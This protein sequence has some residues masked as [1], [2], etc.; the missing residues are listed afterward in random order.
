MPLF[1]RELENRPLDPSEEFSKQYNHFFLAQELA[2]FDLRS[3]SGKIRWEGFSLEQRVSY[4]Q[5]TLPFAQGKSWKDSPPSEYDDAQDFPFSLSFVTPRTVRLRLAARP[6]ELPEEG[7]LMLDGEP[8]TDDS[9]EPGNDCS[10]ATYEGRYGSVVIEFDPFHVEFR[11]ATGGLLTRT[12]HSADAPGELNSLPIPLSFVRRSANLHRH[13]AATFSLAPGERLF[14]GGESFTRL[15]KRGQKMVLWTCDAYGAQTPYMYKPVPFFLSSRGYGIFVHTSAPTTLDLGCS[16]DGAATVF[17]GDDVLDLFFFFGSPKEI[18]TEYTA[19]TGRAPTPPLWT[20]GL[21]MGRESYGSEEETRAVAKK[22]REERIPSDVI[23]LDTD[24]TEVPSRCDFEFSPSRFPDPEKMLSDLKRDGFRVSL[25]QLPYLNPKNDLHDEA[26]EQGYA[27]LSASGR[28]PVD[29]A[30]IDL[31]Y[32]K[33]EAWYKGKLEKLLRTGVGIF[34]ADFGEAAPVAG[35]Y[36]SKQASF[37]EH[38]LY[39]LR[40]NKSVSEATKE[41]SGHGAIYA[42]SAWAGSQRYPVYWSGDAEPTDAAMAA[43]LRAGLSLGLCGFSFWSHFIGG[44]PYPTPPDL[45]LR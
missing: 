43:T 19:L 31:S 12:L 35:T 14:G 3:A 16:F 30:V 34:T 20:F 17:L 13:L 44:F 25:W 41:A 10:S 39:P 21:W 45:Y 38:N 27:V 33:A 8:P 15:D 37:L 26:T 2:E 6:Q 9:W 42:R 5:V 1:D 40:Y 23:H 24:W 11:D 4:H 32:P 22:L 29:D 36:A 18:L 7:S 28:P